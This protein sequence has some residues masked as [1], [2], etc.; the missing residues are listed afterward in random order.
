MPEPRVKISRRRARELAVMGQRL[1]A[2]RP[3][4]VDE[5][6]AALGEIQMDPTSVVARTEHLVLFSRLGP[7]F[8]V[9]QLERRMWT[10]RAMFEYWAHIVPMTDLPMHRISMKRYPHGQWKRHQYVRD[11]L[12]ANDAFVRYAMR[13]LRDRGPLRTRDFENRAAEGWETGG[14]NDEGQNAAMLLDILWS[15]GKVM[16]VGRDGQQRL[17]DLA[18]RWF[19]RVPARS[20]TAMAADLV[21]RQIHARG[22]TRLDRLGSLFDGAMPGRD[23]AVE[24]LLRTGVIVPLRVDSYPGRWY[25]HRDLLD[26]SFRGRTVALS[27][28]DD[29]VSDRTRT[30]RLFDMYY[31]IE[32]YVPKAKRW[33][34]FVLPVLRGDRLVGRL[35]PSWERAERVLTIKAWQMQPETDAADRDA[36]HE[37]IDELARWLRAERVAFPRTKL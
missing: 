10:D 35:D 37:A 32:I 14:W 26:R 29:L 22:I 11:W 3:R 6:L 13:E 5:V 16:I 1:D 31:R 17:W 8:R 18:S 23:E 12:V 34:Y 36:V 19:P 27:P 24:R 25:T 21:E 2:P 9:S 7:S 28:F 15:Q 20:R 30:E 33:G 4:S